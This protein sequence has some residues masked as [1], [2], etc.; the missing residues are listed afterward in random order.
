MKVILV[1]GVPRFYRP[2]NEEEEKEM[3]MSLVRAVREHRL[4]V[5]KAHTQLL[6]KMMKLAGKNVE[7][8]LK[9]LRS[10]STLQALCSTMYA[11]EHPTYESTEVSEVDAEKELA[12]DALTQIRERI[13]NFKPQPLNRSEEK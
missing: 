6:N 1:D 7:E 9:I 5:P 3:L 8:A 12:P 2:E 13:K 4:T 11:T 10:D